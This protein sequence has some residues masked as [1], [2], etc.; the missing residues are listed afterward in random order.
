MPSLPPSRA[1][2][3]D[4]LGAV[5][6]VEGALCHRV[7]SAVDGIEVPSRNVFGEPIVLERGT[8]VGALARRCADAA[9]RGERVALVAR[10]A[11]LAAARG[12][13]AE[14]AASRLAV[15]VHVLADPAPWGVPASQ[16]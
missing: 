14:I 10:A 8:D 3:R 12:E 2:A 1:W 15:V 5:G 4:V 6:L 13:L 9:A 7:L 11:D 16:G